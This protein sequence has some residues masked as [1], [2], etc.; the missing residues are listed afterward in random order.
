MQAVI[1][2]H[3][4]IST[5]MLCALSATAQQGKYEVGILGGA[6]VYQGDL[7]PRPTGS[8]KTIATGAGIFASKRLSQAL[9]LKASFTKATLKGNEHKYATPAYS[10]QRALQFTGKV[11]ELT[12]SL[13]YHFLGDN[14]KD[15]DPLFSPYVSAGAGISF[16]KINR[17]YSR[18]N[19]EYF[20]SDANVISGLNADIA[21]AMPRA[22]TVLPIGA[23]LRY[24]I[25]QTLQLQA[26]GL[27]RFTFTDYLDGFSKVANSAK[28][29]SY[30][31]GTIG[32]VYRFAGK[33]SSS[34]PVIKY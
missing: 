10:Q 1:K 27:Y 23:G 19:Y 18:F 32:I 26:E 12:A 9:W 4:F 20:G 16:V 24:K 22:I 33:N 34:C 11:N 7:S 6:F 13:S 15:G 8:L 5:V 2:T 30:Y 29:D 17:D 21:Q 14:S 31:G 25:S 3:V 28:N